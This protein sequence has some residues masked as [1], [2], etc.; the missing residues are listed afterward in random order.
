MTQMQASPFER[1]TIYDA[2]EVIASSIIDGEFSPSG[3]Y[4]AI[5]DPDRLSLP[6]R[7]GVA[8]RLKEAA[9]NTG[10]GNALID[11]ATNPWV[12]LSFVTSVPGTAALG[13][14]ASYMWKG[15]RSAYIRKASPFLQSIGLY[16]PFQSLRG[17]TSG[18]AIH[19]VGRMIDNA[20]AEEGELVGKAYEAM[21]KK[22]GLR[23]LD[24]TDPR[25]DAA[26]QARAKEIAFTLQGSLE[27]WDKSFVARVMKHPKKINWD[28]VSKADD[29]LQDKQVERL[30][31]DDLTARLAATAGTEGV[32]LRDALRNSMK[33]RLIRLYGKETPATLRSLTFTAD[34]EKIGNVYRGFRNNVVN[35]DT[36]SVE[37]VKSL[38]GEEIAGQVAS[39]KMSRGQFEALIGTT[40]EQQVSKNY[41]PRNMTERYAAPGVKMTY[42]DQ[43]AYMYNRAMNS[44]LG[45][46][47]S[48][49]SRLQAVANYHPEDLAYIGA[50]FKGTPALT[51]EL[52]KANNRMASAGSQSK[53]G[54]TINTM[55]YRVQPANAY[56][57]HMEETA[58]TWA[59]HVADPGD[60]VRAVAK[61]A[62]SAYKVQPHGSD[63]LFDDAIY[64]KNTIKDLRDG[65]MK[66]T[67]KPSL[68]DYVQ[69]D[70]QLLAD[71]YVRHAIPNMLVP[72]IG[73]QYAVKRLGTYAAAMQSK[74]ALGAIANGPIGKMME[75]VGAHGFVNELK[76]LADP[77]H[78]KDAAG[79]LTRGLAKFLYVTHLGLNMSS[80]ALNMMQPLLLAT[81]WLG[82]GNVMKAYGSAFKEMWGYATERASMGVGPISDATKRTL[83]QKH[84]KHANINGE[85]VLGIAPD[86]FE[87]LEGITFGARRPYELPGKMTVAGD[88]MMKLFEKAEWLNRTVTAHAVENAYRGS[89]RATTGNPFFVKDVRETVAE[90]QFGSSRMNTPM[91]FQT[92]DSELTS[93]GRILANPLMRQFLGFPA[94]MATAVTS[95]TRQVGGREGMLPIVNDF[96]RGMAVSAVVYEVGKNVLGADLS[97]GLYASGAVGPLRGSLGQEDAPVPIPPV[98]DIPWKLTQGL[99]TQDME[100][101]ERTIPRVIP[102][103]IALSRALGMAPRVGLPDPFNLQR[104]YADWNAQDEQGNIPIYEGTGQL[105]GHQDPVDL[106]LRSLGADLS[107]FDNPAARDRYLATQ[108]EEVRNYRRRAIN[109]L[110]GGDIHRY[111]GVTA[112]FERRFK[113]PLTIS[114]S[115][116]DSAM[117]VRE[118]ARGDRIVDQLPAA[119]REDYRTHM[120]LTG[121]P[122]AN[123][124]PLQGKGFGRVDSAMRS[125][126]VGNRELDPAAIAEIRRLIDGEEPSD[127]VVNGQPSFTSY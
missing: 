40:F 4:A 83:I 3:A 35:G 62:W 114:K 34:P 41:F 88:Y 71:P 67:G 96:L 107:S 116:L 123:P 55:F 23:S 51:Q 77:E 121:G 56:H 43:K 80:A 54:R 109:H 64:G 103:G 75:S 99:A 46:G 7:E 72:M 52:T 28:T 93:F 100:L 9:G 61:D 42:D 110:I 119:S 95:T 117:R 78:G 98:I 44:G 120:Q 39:G 69:G 97:K 113:L 30:V 32:A 74:Q 33:L 20:R 102:G 127:G 6:E 112:E 60:E 126:R 84:F 111:K 82:A 104:Q 66:L 92:S 38:F 106:V 15:A 14:G 90:A 70:Y 85:D 27:G 58:R 59:W 19:H 87:S 125:G 2:P 48:A 18:S 118:E 101:L 122:P 21:L 79:L 24:F 25:M 13:R 86:I 36:A 73:G 76:L 5:M 22:N 47:R 105:I 10:V 94:R 16:T 1:L 37:Y 49:L 81:T 29:I 63:T 50:N 57:R 91:A 17:T 124:T 26:Q 45:S 53:N 11:I 115:Q 8:S 89:G 68:A 108:A 12:W 31:G 65:T